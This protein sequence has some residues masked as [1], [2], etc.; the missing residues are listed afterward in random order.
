MPATI[1]HTMSIREMLPRAVMS[2][3]ELIHWTTLRYMSN[4]CE[5]VGR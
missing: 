4:Q 1:P 3:G 5:V 2:T